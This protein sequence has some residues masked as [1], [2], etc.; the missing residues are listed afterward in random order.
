MI[1][2]QCLRIFSISVEYFFPDGFSPNA[3]NTA[4]AAVNILHDARSGC[5]VTFSNIIIF[6]D[7]F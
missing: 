1:L 5:F 6:S 2:K 7:R 4:N 3:I